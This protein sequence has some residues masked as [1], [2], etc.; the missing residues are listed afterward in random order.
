LELSG[1]N[2]SKFLLSCIRDFCI[3]FIDKPQQIQA[4]REQYSFVYPVLHERARCIWAATETKHLGWGGISLVEEAL[5]LAFE[6]CI[7]LLAK[8]ATRTWLSL[9]DI[10][11]SSSL[12]FCDVSVF[13]LSLPDS[14]PR[15]P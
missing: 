10:F 6:N 5:R 13:L 1:N 7:A 4:I 9:A 8:R 11:D 2:I 3:I 14:L 12:P 15:C